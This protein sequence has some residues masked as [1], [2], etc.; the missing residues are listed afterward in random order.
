MLGTISNAIGQGAWPTSGSMK[1]FC[2]STTTR[3][4]LAGTKSSKM[5]SR[6]RRA[7]TRS[8][9]DCE[10]DT[11]CMASPPGRTAD[12]ASGNE[13]KATSNHHLRRGVSLD[14][15]AR[16][17]NDTGPPRNLGLEEG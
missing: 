16:G 14:F 9:I 10:T 15:D 11:L 7:T 4:V 8:T 6:P 13:L 3:A 5:C 12:H 2:I 1:P 17:L